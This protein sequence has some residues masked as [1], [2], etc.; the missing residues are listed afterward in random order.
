MKLFFFFFINEGNGISTVLFLHPVLGQKINKW[1]T[2]YYKL[3][4]KTY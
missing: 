4:M 1:K 3:K 2:K